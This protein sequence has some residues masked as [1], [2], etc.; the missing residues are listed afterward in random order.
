MELSTEV[1]QRIV[2]AKLFIDGH[3]GEPVGLGQIATEACL[4]RFHFHRLFTRI[5]KRTP[6]QYLTQK[7]MDAARRLLQRDDMTISEVCR[8]AGFESPGSFRSLFRRNTGCSPQ[9][10]RKL[11]FLKRKLVEEQPKSFVPHCFVEQYRL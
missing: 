7:R 2:A 1:Y 6:H 10:Y 9:H 3:Y 11:V 8:Q 4:S 5:Y